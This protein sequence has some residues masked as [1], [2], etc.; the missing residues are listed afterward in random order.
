[1]NRFAAVMAFLLAALSGA[2]SAD[3]PSGGIQDERID[4][5]VLAGKWQVTHQDG[6]L[7]SMSG[8]VDLSENADDLTLVLRYAGQ[9]FPLSATHSR[10][11]WN[12][13][14]Y[15]LEG[16][17]PAARVSSGSPPADANLVLAPPGTIRLSATLG[18]A[19]ESVAV[20]PTEQVVAWELR[21]YPNRDGTARADW[22]K[23]LADGSRKPGGTQAWRTPGPRLD[24]IVVVYDQTGYTEGVVKSPYPFGNTAHDWGSSQRVLLFWGESLVRGYRGGTRYAFDAMGEPI[25]YRLRSDSMTDAGHGRDW[26]QGWERARAAGADPGRHEAI[27]VNAQLDEGVLPGW[28]RMALNGSPGNWKLQFGDTTAKLSFVREVRAGDFEGT[29]EVLPMEHVH[30]QVKTEVP[31]PLGEIPLQVGVD[32]AQQRLAGRGSVTVTR[33][34]DGKSTLYRTPPIALHSADK[35]GYRPPPKSGELPWP[36]KAGQVLLAKFERR[37]EEQGVLRPVPDC[38]SPLPNV[39]SVR[40]VSTPAVVGGLWEEALARADRCPG[41]QTG[42]RDWAELRWRDTE[43]VDRI[44]NLFV[45]TLSS[46]HVKIKFGHQAA[47]ILLRDTFVDMM[48]GV[49]AEFRKIRSSTELMLKFRSHMLSQGDSEHIPFNRVRVKAPDGVGIAYWQTHDVAWVAGRHGLSEEQAR[50]WAFEQTVAGL[51]AYIASMVHAID[52]AQAAGDCDTPELLDVTG[53]GFHLVVERLLPRLMQLKQ[54]PDL[55]PRRG[56]RLSAAEI[57]A[58]SR[59]KPRMWWAPD[60]VA[61]GWV[62]SVSTLA[63]AVKDQR[64]AKKVDDIFVDILLTAGSV[65]TPALM[66]EGVLAL[67]VSIGLDAAD[68]AWTL[69]TDVRDYYES[70]AETAFAR[71]ASEVLG[72]GRAEQAELEQT[73][74]FQT[75]VG[76]LGS[77]F[78]VSMTAVETAAAVNRGARLMNK[79]RAGGIQVLSE[80]EKADFFAFVKE[81]KYRQMKDGADALSPRQSDGLAMVDDYLDQHGDYFPKLK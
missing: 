47:M 17:F 49:L 58:M 19:S 50:R 4:H 12:S 76:V 38:Q 22:T 48:R 26:Q 16:D 32:G 13:M 65:V 34:G 37:F 2:P 78:G 71:G 52:R 11:G 30:L 31:L 41:N 7:G 72:T 59:A 81:A 36:V 6:E 44:T 73:E 46:M 67:V 25:H 33:V 5:R 1:M 9:R 61:R 15:R 18:K 55:R 60:T 63:Q 74:W 77:A 40:V 28:K 45:L 54:D 79:V 43:E 62:G 56:R 75:A 57:A 69:H 39:S 66:G 14:I 68:V 80:A 29:C 35:D 70:R 51:D 64:A 42:V 27:L 3:K 24:G 21:V 53:L 10:F 20:R 8:T 23:L